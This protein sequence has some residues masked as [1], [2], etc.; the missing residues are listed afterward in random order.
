MSHCTAVQ[1]L[2]GNEAAIG[3]QK[4]TIFGCWYICT[5]VHRLWTCI[6]IK[7]LSAHAWM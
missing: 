6:L 2:H 4:S 7:G 3:S 5:V 1:L